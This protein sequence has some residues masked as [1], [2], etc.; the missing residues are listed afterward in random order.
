MH[1]TSSRDTQQMSFEPI[2]AVLFYES[3]RGFRN[4][5]GELRP[6]ANLPHTLPL[7]GAL[8]LAKLGD[9]RRLLV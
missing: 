4:K 9:G 8:T 2:D 6:E 1:D 3:D 5:R 7:S